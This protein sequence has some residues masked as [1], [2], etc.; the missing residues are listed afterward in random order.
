MQTV[1][2]IIGGYKWKVHSFMDSECENIERE[3]NSLLLLLQL[4]FRGIIDFNNWYPNII[5]FL[6]NHGGYGLNVILALAMPIQ[7]PT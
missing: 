5:F 2:N 1:Y 3:S 4:R 7:T 6:Q